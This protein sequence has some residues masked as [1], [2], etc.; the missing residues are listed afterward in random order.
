VEAALFAGL[1]LVAHVHLAGLVVTHQDDG[2]PR[3]DAPGL[4][5]VG[6]LL[7]IGTQL[8]GKGL[9]IDQLSSHV[10]IQKGLRVLQKPGEPPAWRAELKNAP[11]R[12]RYRRIAL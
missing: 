7:D 6:A 1:D 10:V 12:N 2:Q 3:H 5:L 8:L 9:A 4:E 11:Y